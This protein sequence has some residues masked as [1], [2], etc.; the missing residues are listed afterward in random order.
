MPAGLAMAADDCNLQIEYSQRD[1]WPRKPNFWELA[2]LYVL[3]S[4]QLKIEKNVLSITWLDKRKHN[5]GPRALDASPTTLVAD[6]AAGV[7]PRGEKN[8]RQVMKLFYKED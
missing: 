5:P 2:T 3:T 4:Y 8:N 7:I 1:R 6:A